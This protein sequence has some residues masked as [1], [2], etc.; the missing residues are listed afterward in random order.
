MG[1]YGRGDNYNRGDYYRGDYYRGDFLGIGHF[2]GGVAKKLGGVVLHAAEAIP[3]IG[4]AVKIGEAAYGIVAGGSHPN[5][6]AP[7]GGTAL[8]VARAQPSLMMADPTQVGLI[9][10]GPAGTSQYGLI[11][12]ASSMGGLPTTK[13]YHPNKSTY[14]TRGGG[15]SRWGGAGNVAI[16]PKGTVLVKNRRMNVG[17]ARALKRAL[18]RAHGFARL[19]RKVMSFTHPGKAGRGRFKAKRRR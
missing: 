7:P 9:N 11:N 17:N 15:T 6:P 18:R 3:G 1:H 14:E 16:H 19:A 4:T 2:L 12:S 10:R 13:G 8:A 5:L